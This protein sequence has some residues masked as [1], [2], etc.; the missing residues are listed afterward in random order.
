MAPDHRHSRAYI[1]AMR[2]HWVA[3]RI[4]AW[5]RRRGARSHDDHAVDEWFV[6]GVWRRQPNR[7]NKKRRALLYTARYVEYDDW[8]LEGKWYKV[9][10]RHNQERL[11]YGACYGRWLNWNE[12]A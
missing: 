11:D 8:R 6:Q 4:A 10:R 1:V 9:R 3:K 12:A 5:R 2:A 7:F